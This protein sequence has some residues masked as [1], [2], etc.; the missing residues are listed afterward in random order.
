[1]TKPNL[2]VLKRKELAP[3]PG[4]GDKLRELAARADSGELRGFALVYVAGP[5]HG[6][7]F[8]YL[9]QGEVLDHTWTIRGALQ[10]LSEAIGDA[11]AEADDA[12]SPAG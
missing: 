4:L 7:D 9:F 1:M 2:S 11:D 12:A 10:E 5:E 8:A 3:Y 6:E